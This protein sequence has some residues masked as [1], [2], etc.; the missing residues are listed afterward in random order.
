[1]PKPRMII[2]DAGRTLL[3]HTSVSTLRGVRAL[4]EYITENP[5]G[6]TAE[7]IDERVNEIAE[8]FSQSRKMLFE[9]PEQ[10]IWA[11]AFDIMQLKF[12]ISADEVEELLWWTTTEINP[13]PNADKALHEL[14]ELGIETA[15][16]SNLDSPSWLLKK[17][18]DRVYPDNHFKF[19]IASS[20]YGIRKPNRLIFEAGIAKSSFKPS[21]IWYIG[22]KIS[23]D[24][25]GSE[26][27][28]MVP[29][30]YKSPMNTY[31]EIPEGLRTID[32]FSEL[33]PLIDAEN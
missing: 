31:G 11:L 15:V 17:R 27:A 2:F 32:D 21:E 24:V 26:N 8:V 4:M 3:H 20:D 16:I 7:Q 28:G 1:M 23:V 29:V 13:A 10:N 5:L 12:S 25:V 9:V 6:L 30:L 19:I 33:I 18:M 22:D 14:N